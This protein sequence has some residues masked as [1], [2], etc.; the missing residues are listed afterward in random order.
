ML[1]VTPVP[2]SNECVRKK[3]LLWLRTLMD[4]YRAS[5]THDVFSYLFFSLFT[6]TSHNISLKV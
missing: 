3:Y 2:P 4:G 6:H 5:S 1:S